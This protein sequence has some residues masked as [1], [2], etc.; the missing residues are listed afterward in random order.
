[1]TGTESAESNSERIVK[2]SLHLS[3]L[4]LTP[5]AQFLYACL[6]LSKCVCVYLSLHG[7]VCV[8]VVEGFSET[9]TGGR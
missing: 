2:I 1:M 4:Y 6:N 3:K 8:C 9:E 7:C 5:M